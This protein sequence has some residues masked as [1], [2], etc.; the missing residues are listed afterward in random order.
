MSKILLILFVLFLPLNA[1]HA[2]STRELQETIKHVMNTDQSAQ[3]NIIVNA[4]IDS[5]RR[6]TRSSLASSLVYSEDDYL[7]ARMRIMELQD[8]ETDYTNYRAYTVTIQALEDAVNEVARPVKAKIRILTPITPVLSA[9]A[10]PVGPPAGAQLAAPVRGLFD[11]VRQ[12]AQSPM[13]SDRAMSAAEILQEDSRSYAAVAKFMGRSGPRPQ[14]SAWV[15]NQRRQFN[16]YSVVGDGDCAL[17]GLG[18]T[19]EKFVERLAHEILDGNAEIKNLVTFDMIAYNTAA[20][21][22]Q[23]KFNPAVLNEM[24]DFVFHQ[25]TKKEHYLDHP[26]IRAAAHLYGKNVRI[27]KTLPNSRELYKAA[28]DTTFGKP[29]DK[30]VN[31]YHSGQH[32]DL[33]VDGLDLEGRY[34]ATLRE[35]LWT[36]TR[37]AIQQRSLETL[38]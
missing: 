2:T 36:Q 38:L 29:G 23:L 6:N 26:T 33:L 1:A 20:S 24:L 11:R 3:S 8:K 32:Y 37:L 15:G 18:I 30:F 22:D 10:C 31:L 12:I 4:L 5:L 17:H 14:Y 9:A 7:K 21:A 16:L 27:W 25:M 13:P 35:T 19:R 34:D 28:D